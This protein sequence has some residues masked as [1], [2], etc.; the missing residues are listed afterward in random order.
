MVK[1]VLQGENRLLYTYGVTNSGKTYTIQGK[2]F[3]PVLLYFSSIKPRLDCDVGVCSSV[4]LKSQTLT[5]RQWS[6][7]RSPAPGFSVSVQETAG[8]S[9]WCH[10]PEA[11]HV[12]RCEAAWCWWG[13]GGGNPQ[14][15]SAQRGKQKNN[16]WRS[17]KT[18]KCFFFVTLCLLL[19][20][21]CQ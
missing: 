18:K 6:R 19:P 9:L 14:K 17:Y 16:F 20:D 4:N 11:C 1:D 10:G 15:L 13:Q 12:S 7:G 2:I 3:V 8:S 5:R 21:I